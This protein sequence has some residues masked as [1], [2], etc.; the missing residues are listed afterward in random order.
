MRINN[1]AIVKKYETNQ[2]NGTGNTTY[3]NKKAMRA[4]LCAWL[5]GLPVFTA[6]TLPAQVQAPPLAGY[7]TKADAAL[8]RRQVANLRQDVAGMKELLDGLLF[9]VKDLERENKML[10]EQVAH[11]QRIQLNT[12]GKPSGVAAADVDRV[13]AAL[14]TQVYKDL[15]KIRTEFYKNQG[16]LVV[17]MN[18][19]L[20]EVTTTTTPAAP[21]PPPASS[22]SSAPAPASSVNYEEYYEHKVAKNDTLYG[23]FR[24][25]KEYNV[26]ISDIKSVNNI[27]NPD[28]LKVGQ[29]LILP[30][31]K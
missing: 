16:D 17:K 13:I 20:K 6:S 9:T 23:I 25:Y 21:P 2:L 22:S 11:M 27:T 12:A 30:V 4:A 10:K 1:E 15:E 28:K 8:L 5:C 14:R 29:T 7:E 18:S 26:H 3:N 19:A 31:R 24:Q